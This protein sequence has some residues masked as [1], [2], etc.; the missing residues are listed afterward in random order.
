MNRLITVISSGLCLAF[1][2]ATPCLADGNGE[3]HSPHPNFNLFISNQSFAMSNVDITVSIDNVTVVNDRFPVEDQ[4]YWRGFP[5]SLSNGTHTLVAATQTG[6]TN[7]QTE[8]SINS[9]HSAL[10]EF[11]YYPDK[12]SGGVAL[13]PPS[14]SFRMNQPLG[15]D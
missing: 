12:S 8:F 9:N 15:I 13:T 10:L 2:A 4:H 7:L 3:G 1:L 5:I 6:A 11:W 14:F